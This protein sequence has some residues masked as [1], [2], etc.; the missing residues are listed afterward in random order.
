MTGEELSRLHIAGDRGIARVH[1][2]ILNVRVPQAILYERHIR[3][4]VE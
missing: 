2:R 3:A 4:S 1:H